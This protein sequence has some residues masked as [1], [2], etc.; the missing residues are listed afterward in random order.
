MTKTN[1]NASELEKII[2]VRDILRRW[3]D[4]AM[5]GYVPAVES[6]DDKSVELASEAYAALRVFAVWARKN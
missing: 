2:E 5:E 4:D 6:V 3:V 1:I